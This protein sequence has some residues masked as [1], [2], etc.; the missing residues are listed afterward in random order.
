MANDV[1]NNAYTKRDYIL[2]GLNWVA[3]MATSYSFER[4]KSDN[5]QSFLDEVRQRRITQSSR[6]SAITEEKC[7]A[8]SR[9]AQRDW[10]L[11]LGHPRGW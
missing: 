7:S 6:D 11:H 2:A 10:R 4:G 8:E 1:V 9:A 5:F 3:D